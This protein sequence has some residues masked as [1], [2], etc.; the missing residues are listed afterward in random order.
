MGNSGNME[1]LSEVNC[2]WMNS[3]FARHLSPNLI[4]NKYID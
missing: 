4:L 2:Q 1:R 3:V